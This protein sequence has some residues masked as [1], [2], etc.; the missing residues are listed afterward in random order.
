MGRGQKHRGI[1]NPKTKALATA[2]FMRDIYGRTGA[3][4]HVNA[5]PT[6]Y[7]TKN[8]TQLFKPP[9]A[10][11]GALRVVDEIKKKFAKASKPCT[12]T[13]HFHGI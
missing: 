7:D 5:F 13:N 12:L 9:L 8:N 3:V 2:K 1:R 4:N 10:T 6:L 11:P